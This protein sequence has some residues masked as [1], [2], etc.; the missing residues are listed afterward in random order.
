MRIALRVSRII[1]KKSSL[2][3][4]IFLIREFLIP[5]NAENFDNRR[6]SVS[7]NLVA[8]NLNSSELT[9]EINPNE[10]LYNAAVNTFNTLSK[11]D[12]AALQILLI[13]AGV[14]SHLPE[15]N[16]SR[17]L[18][19]D[20]KKFQTALGHEESGYLSPQELK[21]ISDIAK[22][23]FSRWN[24]KLFTYPETIRFI[25][26]P[27]KLITRA[28]PGNQSYQFI[29]ELP[30]AVAFS[31]ISGLKLSSAYK[32]SQEMAV[33]DNDTIII[34]T[35]NKNYFLIKKK[36][37]DG[38]ITYERSHRDT[39]G[40]TSLS[41][42]W[43]ENISSMHADRLALI[44]ASSLKSSMGEGLPF[45]VPD[46]SVFND[47]AGVAEGENS[48]SQDSSTFSQ[49]PADRSKTQQNKVAEFSGT[50]FFVSNQAHIITNAHVVGQCASIE[51]S[52]D[53]MGFVP[54]RLIVSDKEN[55]IALLKSD[56]APMKVSTIR[57]GARL[58]EQVVAYGFPLSSFLSKNGN[59]T[60]GNVTALAG[61]H[62]D[63]RYLQISTPVQ[64]GNSGGPLLDQYGNVVGVVTAKLNALQAMSAT[65]D[66]PQNVNFA[67]KSSIVINFLE[68]NRVT[69]NLGRTDS[70]LPTTDLADLSRSISVFI[71]CH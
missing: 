44:I 15:D 16:F 63:T 11:K 12:K 14:T 41:I 17:Q 31:H 7:Q 19:D 52:T 38:I 36:S 58:G 71:R 26:L 30:P 34:K 51:V 68:G 29:G 27:E 18:F 46:F 4:F 35:Y 45:V 66:I 24:L 28:T 22:P 42:A 21:Y 67:L 59:F 69:P 61:W 49:S 20:I 70:A 65:G 48:A 47:S 56:F 13:G 5:V 64:P 32:I 43:N 54:A 6:F 57:M 40:V 23:I 50:G 3:L 25:A 55:D 1:H 53:T 33:R 8:Q 39:D 60:L 62:D 37:R 2:V 9:K 10:I